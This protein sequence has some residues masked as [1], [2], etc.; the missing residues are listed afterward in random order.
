M[1]KMEDAK[2]LSWIQTS[3]IAV[4]GPVATA[5]DKT[6]QMFIDRKG[7]KTFSEFYTQ[8]IKYSTEVSKS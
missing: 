2:W 5:V 1:S 3:E 8:S 4:T 6:S 7:H